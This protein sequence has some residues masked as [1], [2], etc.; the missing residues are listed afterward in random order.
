[1]TTGTHRTSEPH[2]FAAE[3]RAAITPRAALFVIGV[4]ALQVGFILSYI[5]A[6]HSPTPHELPVGVVAPPR[7]ADQVNQT[8]NNLDDDPIDSRVVADEAAARRMIMDR[9]IDA[10]IIINPAQTTDTL[11]IASAGGPAVSEAATLL[12]TEIDAQNRRQITTVDIQPPAKGDGRGLSSFYLVIG[13]MVGGYLV[14]SIISVISGARANLPR[15]AIRLGVLALYALASGLAGAIIVGPTLD[16]LPGHFTALWFIGALLVFA[17]GAATMALQ[18]LFGIAGIGVAILFFVVLGNPSAGGPYPATL[19]PS[20]W[21]TIGPLLPP[22]A[23]TTI[24]RNTV[25]FN[26]HDTAQA[27]WVLTAYA[28][29][30]VA[31]T[32]GAAIVLYQRRNPAET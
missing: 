22:G 9:T 16:A 13:W 6:F 14:A 11:L 10:A 12:A 15:A 24:V 21:A 28:V 1:M 18:A 17:V 26:G 31:V 29:V 27:Y 20:F 25:Y 4:F 3:L 19:L 23:G 8:L 32:L 2:G 30:G 7:I 5:G